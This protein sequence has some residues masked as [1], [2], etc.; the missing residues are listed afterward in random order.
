MNDPLFSYCPCQDQ[1]MQKA[2]KIIRVCSVI[3]CAMIAALWILG[4]VVEGYR[5]E[6]AVVASIAPMMMIGLF[7][8]MF[9]VSIC[10]KHEY[11][12]V[13]E[14]VIKYRNCFSKEAKEIRL[15][16]SDYRIKVKMFYGRGGSYT[17]H[18]FFIGQN[19]RRV[20]HYTLSCSAH[21][22]PQMER[23]LRMIGCEISGLSKC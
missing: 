10:A 3:M 15:A 13:Y 6:V 21:M 19:Q 18:L 11:L 4:L 20:L 9:A 22:L 7:G 17:I 14:D 23:K 12:L 16:P 8:F 5:G 2:L 1:E